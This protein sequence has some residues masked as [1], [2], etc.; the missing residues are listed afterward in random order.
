MRGAK[1][2]P[3]ATLGLRRVERKTQHGLQ[4][5]LLAKKV[6][7]YSLTNVGVVRNVK[8]TASS[9]RQCL[10]WKTVGNRT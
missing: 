2:I 5:C 8:R 1:E 10:L 7:D 6:T 3:S 9:T 4:R